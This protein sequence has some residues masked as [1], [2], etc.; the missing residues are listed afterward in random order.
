MN[1]SLFFIFL[2]STAA[3]AQGQG[4]TI[5]SADIAY[6]QFNLKESNSILVSILTIDTVQ[7]EQTCNV[8]RRLAHQDWKYY[9]NYA[10]AKERLRKADSIGYEKYET[11]MLLS[12]IERESQ[13]SMRPYM[14]H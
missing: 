11:W 4:N 12:R 7:P 5:E 6:D 1:K 3:V 10:L 13:H 2:L 8:L 14:Q 9:Q